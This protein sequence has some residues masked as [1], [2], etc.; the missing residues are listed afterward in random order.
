Q[1][2]DQSRWR[3]DLPARNRRSAARAS[4]RGRGGLL[5]RAAWNLGG[6]GRRR[7]GPPRRGHGSRAPGVLP[8]APGRLQ[9]AEA[10]PHRGDHPSHG[11]RQ[12]SARGRG[13][14]LQA[15]SLV[16]IVIAG[17]GA[18]GGYIGARLAKAGGDVVLYARGPHLHAM[19]ARGLR[20]VSPDGD[21]EVKPEVTGDLS[22]IER[23]D[24]IVL[25]VKAHS[26]TTLAPQLAPL[27][28]PDTVVV[29]TQNGIPWWYFLTCGSGRDKL[30]LERVDPGGVIE[31]AIEERR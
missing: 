16:K 11:D 17:A 20:V 28:G 8:R 19:Q 29:S 3:K 7:G 25:G 4:C 27:L 14:G 26:L 5:R 22:A 15:E 31:A 23:A 9:A 2:A 30:R 24:V 18:I 13:E 21:F 6:R 1:R 12:D 10:D